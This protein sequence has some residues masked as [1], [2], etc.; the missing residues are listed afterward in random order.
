MGERAEVDALE[1]EVL[2]GQA[3]EPQQPID[4]HIHRPARVGDAV[5]VAERLGAE[6]G[7]AL[8]D[9]LGAE[10]VDRAQRRAQVVRHRV[11]EGLELLVGRAQL[12]GALEHALLELLVEAAH[13]AWLARSWSTT[14]ARRAVSARARARASLR[15]VV[16]IHSMRAAIA[17][18]T[19]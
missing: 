9:H 16:V 14:S 12:A 2:A 15:M 11:G 6:H 7:A 10:A 17:E 13:W 3:G 4:E 8:L 5:E 18:S 1:V 19:R